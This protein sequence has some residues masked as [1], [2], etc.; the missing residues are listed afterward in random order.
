M[1]QSADCVTLVIA[2]PSLFTTR[3]YKIE[4][5]VTPEITAVSEYM[6]SLLGDCSGDKD[7]TFLTLRVSIQFLLTVDEEEFVFHF[8]F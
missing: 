3:V 2:L 4:G 1:D 7:Q 5:K 6:A 8:L